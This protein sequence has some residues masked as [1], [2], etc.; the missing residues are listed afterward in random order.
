M[1]PKLMYTIYLMLFKLVLSG[2]IKMRY[3]NITVQHLYHVYL[4]YNNL[5]PVYAKIMKSNVIFMR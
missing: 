2:I 3:S 1:L 4:G 5:Q